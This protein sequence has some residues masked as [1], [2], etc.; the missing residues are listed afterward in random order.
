MGEIDIRLAE[1][2][3]DMTLKINEIRAEYEAK[4]DGL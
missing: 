1:I 4:A 3:G 2:E